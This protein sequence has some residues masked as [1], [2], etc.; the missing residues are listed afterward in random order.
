MA[1]LTFAGAGAQI[2]KLNTG[3]YKVRGET[4]G[5]AEVLSRTQPLRLEEPNQISLRVHGYAV[6]SVG[7]SFVY[8]DSNGMP[9]PET[10]EADLP[11]MHHP[12]GVSFVNVVPERIGKV[13]LDLNVYFLD[14][15]VEGG[16]LDTEVVLPDKK[17]EKFYV[18]SPGAAGTIYM[19]TSQMAG[20]AV[21]FPMALYQLAPDPVAIPASLVHFKVIA[22]PDKVPQISINAAN[23]KITA[24][25]TG[26]ALVLTN[27]AGMSAL[28]C[29]DVMANANDGSDRTL[30]RELVPSG[31]A[32]PAMGSSQ[33]RKVTPGRMP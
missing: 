5:R 9:E 30:C 6:H 31:M 24:Q 11:L 2:T 27:F 8:Y 28:T 1:A 7:A 25:H 10:A 26:H 20:H 18:M 14:G 16:R 4:A 33:L 15:M 12:D 17:P 22:P 32:A 13:H 19:D 21:L 23:G 3:G 29:V